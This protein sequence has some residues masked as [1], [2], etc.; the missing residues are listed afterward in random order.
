MKKLLALLTLSAFMVC[1][2]TGC[3]GEN[4][5]SAP[6]LPQYGTQSK[7]VTTSDYST[8]SELTSDLNSENEN[9]FYPAEREKPPVSLNNE[10]S[11]YNESFAGFSGIEIMSETPKIGNSQQNLTGCPAYCGIVCT[12]GDAVYYTAL[13]Y[14]NFLHRK[15][16]GKD[17]IVLEK[18]VWGINIIG[19]QLYC[20]F[21][22]ENPVQNLPLY[23]YGD[24]YRI[25]LK[26]GE[27]SLV[28]T[29][30]ACALTVYEDKL[31]FVYDNDFGDSSCNRVYEC[32]LNGENITERDGA[33]LGF[34]GEYYVGFDEFGQN[35][36]LIN[37]A[38]SEKIRFTDSNSVYNFTVEDGYCYYQSGGS[39]FYR[40]TPE[41]GEVIPMMP[42]ESFNTITY[43]TSETKT[44]TYKTN[45]HFIGGHY[46]LNGNAYLADQEFAF[47]VTPEGKTEIYHTPLIMGEEWYYAGIF[48]DSEKLYSVKYNLTLKQYKLVELQFTDEEYAEGMKTVKEIELL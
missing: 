10:D 43:K 22:S 31:R 11:R 14:D 16:D 9:G 12:D 21:N 44:V 38:T 29:T 37:E 39:G 26:T 48:G 24:I 46:I 32:D 6:V 17:E 42:D 5:T 20:I 40:L 1:A 35:S 19:T 2:I 33:F 28:L 47:K 36:C 13:G 27:M 41:T 34:I 45:G 30:K 25:D 3:N 7:S 15:K 23:S 18:T 4:D 8:V